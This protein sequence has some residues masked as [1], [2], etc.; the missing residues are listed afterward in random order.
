MAD[1]TIDSILV[2]EVKTFIFPAIIGMTRSA[3]GPVGSDADAEIVKGVF[4]ADRN[5]LAPPFNLH[6]LTL[7][8][9]VYRCHDFRCRL[10]M[11]SQAAL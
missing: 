4:L 9:P 8:G 7:P 3:A 11:A 5:R 10:F 2:A 6:G 1:Q